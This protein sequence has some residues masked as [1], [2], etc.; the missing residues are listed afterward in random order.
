MTTRAALVPRSTIACS[1]PTGLTGPVFTPGQSLLLGWLGLLVSLALLA[2]PAAAQSRPAPPKPA[3]PKPAQ[4]SGPAVVALNP[5]AGERP[6]V[7]VT[8][9][10][11][12]RNGEEVRTLVTHEATTETRIRGSALTSRSRSASSKLWRILE[13][14]EQGNTT[15]EHMI[16]HVDMWQQATGR[17]E[18]RYISSQDESPPPQY[19]AQAKTLNI[20]LA[21]VKIDPNGTI[22]ERKS[23]VPEI[24]LGIGPIATPLPGRPIRIGDSWDAPEELRVRLPDGKFERI[25]IREHFTL[26]KVDGDIATIRMRTEAISPV[27]SAEIEVQLVQ[28][29]SKGIIKFDVAQGRVI[30]R[31]FHWDDSV[32]GFSGADSMMKYVARYV[33]EPLPTAAARAIGPERK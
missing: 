18:V 31:E 3:P 33:E 11:R 19:E 24:D 1:L 15:L 21:T 14:D 22:L 10:Y 27:T 7:E 16:T 30:S 9:Q 20:V 6:G 32:V 13:V 26:E 17:P 5:A 28:Q 25:K 4:D 23:N 2:E 8:L 29:M 12:F